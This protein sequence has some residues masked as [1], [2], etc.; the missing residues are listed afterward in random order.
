M[1]RGSIVSP[2]SARSWRELGS[3]YREYQ[4]HVI[5]AQLYDN[6]GIMWIAAE[7]LQKDPA[8]FTELRCLILDGFARLTPI[9]VEFLRRL[10]P[11][12]RA[13]ARVIRL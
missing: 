6:E 13:H 12:T 3:L 1:S 7:C 11:R 10:A 5:Q 2:I 8:L 4:E 9:Q